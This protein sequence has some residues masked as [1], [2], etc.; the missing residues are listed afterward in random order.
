MECGGTRSRALVCNAGGQLH[1]QFTFGPGNLQ[2]IT[3]DE[4]T[5]RLRALQRVAPAPAVVVLAMAGLRTDTDHAR[6]L[7][8]LR[9]QWPHATLSTHHDLH[10][11]WAAG[12]PPGQPRIV[13]LSGTGSCVYGVDL[14]GATARVG[15][16]GH[17]LGD[18]G[19]G[20]HIAHATLR[21]LVETFDEKQTPPALGRTILARLQLNHPDDLVSWRLAAA[22]NDVAALAETVFAAA[23]RN[24]RL[25]RAVI[26]EAAEALA[27]QVLACARKLPTTRHGFE[28]VFAGSTLVN[29]PGFAADV[30][31]RVRASRSSFHATTLD[32]ETVWG[33]IEIA[34]QLF[35]A[36]GGETL[37]STQTN[38]EA[39]LPLSAGPD[40]P[41]S[42]TE[43]RNPRSM[44]LDRL[45]TR[46]AITLMLEEDAALPAAILAESAKIERVIK[47]VERALRAGGRLFYVGAGTS[48]RLG[49]LD[50]SECPPTFRTNPEQVQG[51]IAG[52]QRALWSAME[53]AEDDHDA[54]AAAMAAR[55]VTQN[56]F[57]LG[58]AASGRTPFV[59]GALLEAKRRGA[60]T[61]LLHF[62]TRWK[63]D[64]A[65]KPDVVIR[66]DIGPEVLTG[67]TRL[68]AG[69]AT[70]LVLNLIST[71]TMVRMGKVVGN[72]MV[73]LNPSNTKLRDR[74]TRIVCELT[75]VPPS[76]AVAALERSGWIV[77]DAVKQLGRNARGKR[78]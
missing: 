68:K 75:A 73:D 64:G 62:N 2:L 41:P 36:Q 18:D 9:R 4:L 48:G 20:Y 12:G 29:Q 6:V 54:G 15:G 19:S 56:D 53:G 74:A 27:K 43:D 55:D 76:E 70:K 24:D 30:E 51:I 42:S 60:K 50:A 7:E 21:K 66:P 25:A 57:V 39:P 14:K 46:K 69:T 1:H 11:A 23:A 3:D 45:S 77:K 17:L 16:W 49:V 22:K 13:A 37:V 35:L 32:R 28:L 63:P 47:L 59:H 58:I 65:L 61:G 34:G 26:A 71:L 33:A 5:A 40:A 52:G 31:R 38:V 67:S 10:S 72:L 78:S 8:L 44:N